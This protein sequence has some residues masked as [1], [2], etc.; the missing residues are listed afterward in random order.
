VTLRSQLDSARSEAQH[1]YRDTPFVSIVITS[2]DAARRGDI[3]DLL[4]SIKA[5]AR[6]NFEVIYVIERDWSLHDIV[7]EEAQLAG[8]SV[9]IIRNDSSP[10]LAEARNLGASVAK[11]DVLG[12]VDDDVTLDARW[13][14]TLEAA[15]SS[16]DDLVGATGPSV[17]CTTEVTRWLPQGFHWLISSTAWFRPGRSPDVRNVWGMNMCFRRAALQSV[18]GFSESTGYHRGEMAEDVDLSLRVRANTGKRIIYLPSMRVF[19][20][21]HPYRLSTRYVIARSSWIGYSRR[22]ILRLRDEPSRRA[23][24]EVMVLSS[25]LWESFESLI[26]PKHLN[27]R[28]YSMMS[29]VI[30]LSSLCLLLGYIFG[31]L[32]V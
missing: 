27:L 26:A 10:G 23:N 12:F 3:R 4:V 11:G 21:V 22:A 5:Q 1:H 25:I 28:E 15:F 2:N 16:M 7:A 31:P 18:G 30:L 19:S 20:K 6:R 9:R 8:V 17:P 13:T 14:E 29:R 24:L 32:R